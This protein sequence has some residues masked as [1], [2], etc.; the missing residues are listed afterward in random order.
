MEKA[1]QDLDEGQRERFVGNQ[2]VQGLLS[3]TAQL[4]LLLLLKEMPQSID[5]ALCLAKKQHTVEE[6]QRRLRQQKHGG[7]METVVAVD[8]EEMGNTTVTKKQGVEQGTLFQHVR[9]LEKVVAQIKVQTGSGDTQKRKVVY[10][11]CG[12]GHIKRDCTKRKPGWRGPQNK[13]ATT[14]VP[15]STNNVQKP[16]VVVQGTVDGV[17]Y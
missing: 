8:S 12:E 13:L 11:Q 16:S 4:L 5:D 7:D 1:Y 6:A 10:W 2:L 15:E 17:S 14:W 9:H 3:S